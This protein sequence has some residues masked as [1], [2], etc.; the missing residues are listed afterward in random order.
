MNKDP[1]ISRN[2][3]WS[4]D[5]A[6]KERRNDVISGLTPSKLKALYPLFVDDSK[7]LV[8]Y[9]KKEIVTDPTISI[10]TRD[11]CARYTCDSI[12]STTF[13]T[14][15]QSFNSRNPFVLGKFRQFLRGIADYFLAMFPKKM[16]SQDIHDFLTEFTRDAI[17]VRRDGN[18]KQEDFLSHTIGL[19]DKKGLSNLEATAMC[20]TV[21]LDG[22][23]TTSIVTHYI[24]FELS[25]NKAVQDKLREEIMENVADDGTI[26]YD[27]LLELPYLDQV[28]YET[29]RLNPPVP[30]TTR[31]CSDDVEI[32]GP[33]GS[34]MMIEKGTSFFISIYSLQRNPGKV[35]TWCL[36]FAG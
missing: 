22:Y 9:I 36:S 10:D 32:K 25:K 6:W 5:E 34:K 7:N 35:S 16:V 2:P 3:F 31:V 1:I 30:L 26:S 19:M 27:K 29:L 13:G 17:E 14:E 28:F 11:V 21:I 18:S 33:N 23:E 4:K 8:D 12:C 15:G 20:S 24:L